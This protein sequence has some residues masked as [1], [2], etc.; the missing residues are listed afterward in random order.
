MLKELIL[1]KIYFVEDFLFELRL[2]VELSGTISASD[3]VS[4]S[5]SKSHTT[6]YQPVFT[7]NL[8]EL[9]NEAKKT[10]IEFENFIDI[11]S[12]K[13]KACFYAY[14]TCFFP[15]IIGVDFSEPLVEIANRNKRKLNLQSISFINA[16]AT[17]FELPKQTSFIF[18]FNPF[19]SIVLEKFISNNIDHFKKFNSVIAYANDIQRPSLRKLGFETIFRNQTRKISLWQFTLTQ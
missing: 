1:R 4:K 14:K 3:I 9:L 6:A 17:E 8:R 11:G 13:G 16:D 10:G 15:Y 18:M 2:G 7:R 5:T 19:D 12:G